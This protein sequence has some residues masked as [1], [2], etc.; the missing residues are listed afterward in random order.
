MNDLLES[1]GRLSKPL[2]REI[3]STIGFRLDEES[4]RLLQQRA[5]RLG[6]SRHELA[7]H[8]LVET[9]SEKEERALLRQAIF[10]LSQELQGLRQDL[11]LAAE[12]LLASAGQV[13]DKDAHRWAKGNLNRH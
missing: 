9:L 10:Q 7:R 3:P 5:L 4:L 8:Y 13:T 11:S 6:V 1:T 12:A 2:Q